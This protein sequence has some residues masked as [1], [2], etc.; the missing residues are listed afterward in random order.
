MAFR[1]FSFGVQGFWVQHL[2][3]RFRCG[4]FGVRVFSRFRVSSL[5]FRDFEY[6]FRVRGFAVR[7]FE[8]AVQGFTIGVRGFQGFAFA[9]C[10]FRGSGF[11]VFHGPGFR[12]HGSGIWIRGSG[13]RVRDGSL[14]FRFFEVRDFGFGVSWLD[15]VRFF[16]ARGFGVGV[17]KIKDS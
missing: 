2:G 6:G 3:F 16:E 13:F 1:G 7:S 4:R 15:Q 9:V 5:E 10:V 11:R 12:V 8:L 14:G 17:W